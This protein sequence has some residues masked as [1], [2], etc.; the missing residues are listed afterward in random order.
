MVVGGVLAIVASAVLLVVFEVR[1]L[2][3][4][5]MNAWTMLL[6]IVAGAVALL[7]EDLR[8]RPS[9][10]CMLVIALAPTVA[11][12]IGLL[13]VPSAVLVGITLSWPDGF[14]QNRWQP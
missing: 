9:A 14:P 12:G 4:D 6:A 3:L 10:A 11:G 8:L 7:P 5:T 13:Y 2:G 1:G